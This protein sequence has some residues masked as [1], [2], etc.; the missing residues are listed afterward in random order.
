MFR[1]A[2]SAVRSIRPLSVPYFNVAKTLGNNMKNYMTLSNVSLSPSASFKPNSLLQNKQ[3]LEISNNL[4]VVPVRTV[5]KFSLNKGKRKTVK[6]AVR[7]FFRLHW[8]GWIRTK[9]GKHKKMWKKHASQKQRLRQH[10]FCNATQNTML[11]KMVTKYWKR[12]KHYVE[13]P[14]APYH[15][16]E[17][18]GLT[19]RKPVVR[20]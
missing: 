5:T 4:N 12:P 3:I 10:V 13:D 20:Q 17:E 14:Y 2:I 11:D 19:R 7:R 6:A 15:T 8:G 18:F 16:R 1:F 9:V